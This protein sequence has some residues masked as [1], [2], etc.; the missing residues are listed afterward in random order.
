MSDF[1]FKPKTWG[2]GAYP[3]NW[4]G[5]ALTL[6]FVVVVNLLSLPLMV[7]P[8]LHNIALTPAQ[9]VC[10]A[11]LTAAITVGFIWLCRVKTDG[12][13]KWRTPQKN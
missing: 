13:W 2:Y 9:I 6:G 3:T 7:L 8:A 4:K 10:W 12:E 1:W 11:V 5:W